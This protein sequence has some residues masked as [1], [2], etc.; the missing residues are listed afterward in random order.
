M[1]TLSVLTSPVFAQFS[2]VFCLLSV[3]FAF[4]TTTAIINIIT[5]SPPP[6]RLNVLFIFFSFPHLPVDLA[7]VEVRLCVIGVNL[8]GSGK[9]ALG[10]LRLG[11]APEQ[12]AQV[13]VGAGV[14]GPQ[15]AVVVVVWLVVVVVVVR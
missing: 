4:E 5:F 13:V 1:C 11:Q 7:Q 12:G 8:E 10:L 6:P 9:V 2:T 14:R 3:V 15:S